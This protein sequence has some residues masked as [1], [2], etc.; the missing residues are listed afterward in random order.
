MKEIKSPMVIVTPMI[1][2]VYT[3]LVF[4]P[5]PEFGGIFMYK[6]QNDTDQNRPLDNDS[7]VGFNPFAFHNLMR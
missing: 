4:S 1:P 5:Y 6:S 2:T 3:P 7:M